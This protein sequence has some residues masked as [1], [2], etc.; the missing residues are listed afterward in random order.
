MLHIDHG[1][2]QG[3]MFAIC[4]QHINH[5]FFLQKI[6]LIHEAVGKDYAIKILLD[7]NKS[8]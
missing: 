4:K 8:L 3:N 1:H 7:T 2:P 5:G 6:V